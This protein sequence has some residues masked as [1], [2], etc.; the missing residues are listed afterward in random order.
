MSVVC[1]IDRKYSF[2]RNWLISISR[3][4]EKQFINKGGFNEFGQ[5]LLLI[6]DDIKLAMAERGRGGEN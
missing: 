3:Q 6:W 5:G 1:G 4:N 2:L